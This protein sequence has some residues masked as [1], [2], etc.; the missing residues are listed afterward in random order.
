MANGKKQTAKSNHYVTTIREGAIAANIF[1]GVTPD[2]HAYLYFCLSRSWKSANGNREGYSDRF[3]ER[4][5]EALQT[6]V[7][8]AAEW[9]ERNPNAADAAAVDDSVAEAA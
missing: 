3:Y 1:R 2:G 9:I 4:N 6:V 8:R 5:C 7:T